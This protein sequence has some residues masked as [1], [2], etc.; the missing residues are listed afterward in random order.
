M[1]LKNKT[2]VL[3]GASSGMGKEMARLF[4]REGAQVVVVARR[5]ALLEEL[6]EELRNEPGSIAVFSGDVSELA[7]NEQM[8]DFAV[9][10]F[11]KLDVLVNNAGIMDDMGPVGDLQDEML[12]RVMKVNFYGPVCAIRKAVQVFRQQGNG[13]SIVNIASVGAK[14]TIAGAAYCASKAALTA[15]SQNTAFMYAPDQIRS[16]VIAPG[17]I[18][19]DISHS[20]GR[21][22]LFGYERVHLQVAANPA[23][24]E[25][26]DVA[27]A[28]LFFASDDSAFISGAFLPVDAGWSAG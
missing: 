20:M 1:R 16:N 28:A 13:G 2:V 6:A 15:L 7:V 9:E 21:P 8:I 18:R 17:A 10:K 3:T 23:L 26:V 14:K 4:V 25:G 24:G 12:E 27:K 19:T 22:N 5:Q 11:G